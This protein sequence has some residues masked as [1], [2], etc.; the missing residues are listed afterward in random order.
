VLEA[1]P[2]PAI[3][4]CTLFTLVLLFGNVS[5]A[6][7]NVAFYFA[8]HEDD[9][10]LFMSPNAD[11]DV[12]SPSTKV[13]FIYVTAGDAG[14]G[15]GNAGRSTPFYLAREKAA[16]VSVAFIANGSTDPAQANE[17]VTIIQGHKVRRWSYRNTVSYFLRL[18]DGNMYGNGYL[19]TGSESLKRLHEGA[20]ASVSAVDG[21]ATYQGWADLTKSL[22]NLIDQERE[23]SATVWI[24]IP[25]PDTERNAGDHSDHIQSSQAVLDAIDDLSCINKVLYL[26]YAAAGMPENADTPSREI[27]A[28]TFA[29][30]TVGLNTLGHPS[31][32]DLQHRALLSRHYFRVVRGTGDCF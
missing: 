2:M 18:P 22:R 28:G 7:Q 32:W 3:L 25:D 4:K 8:A 24:H 20:T 21:S 31:N 19:S 9:W 23:G 12:Q 1:F 13:V 29:A 10:Q 14:V 17:S 16:E 15:S 30:V 5:C 11:R 27:K 6:H 26:D